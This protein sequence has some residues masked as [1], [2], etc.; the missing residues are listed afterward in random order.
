MYMVK[1]SCKETFD[2]GMD[3]K[4]AQKQGRIYTTQKKTN[5][6]VVIQEEYR[7]PLFHTLNGEM[8]QM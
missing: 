8:E 5:L 3:V 6:H 4:K 2:A 1:F 7:L